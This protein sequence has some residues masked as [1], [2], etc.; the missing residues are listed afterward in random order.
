M[1]VPLAIKEIGI[2]YGFK[3]YDRKSSTSSLQTAVDGLSAFIYYTYNLSLVVLLQ[4]LRYNRHGMKLHFLLL[5]ALAPVIGL[6][7]Q[8][9]VCNEEKVDSSSFEF[10]RQQAHEKL[11]TFMDYYLLIADGKQNVSMKIYYAKKASSL[12]LPNQNCIIVSKSSRTTRR[13]MEKEYTVEAFFKK[14]VQ[15]LFRE[16]IDVASYEF[17]H[18]ISKKEISENDVEITFCKHGDTIRESRNICTM[19]N[20]NAKS[21]FPK[22]ETDTIDQIYLTKICIEFDDR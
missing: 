10:I 5:F 6:K 21:I 12:F 4:V 15:G 11:K 8:T 14:V 2:H 20:G 19:P 1:D 3:G 7:A 9:P 18:S 16:A 17:C 22:V 13:T